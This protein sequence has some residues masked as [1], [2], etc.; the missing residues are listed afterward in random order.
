MPEAECDGEFDSGLA[1]VNVN[2][3]L[4]AQSRAI[5]AEDGGAESCLG[6]VSSFFGEWVGG[7]PM[8]EVRGQVE[9]RVFSFFG[10]GFGVRR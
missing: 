3:N 6:S 4:N 8:T 7:S 1:I 10:D 2:V 9:C 5:C